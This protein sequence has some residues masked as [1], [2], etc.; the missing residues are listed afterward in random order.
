MTKCVNINHPDFKRLAIQSNLN[1]H[2]LSAKIGVWMEENNTDEFPTLNDLGIPEYSDTPVIN[3]TF[4][5]IDI[6]LSDRA[7]QVFDKGNKNNWDLNKIL[8]ELQIPK[9]QKELLLHL[10]IKDR[11]ELAIQLASSYGFTI[12]INTTKEKQA[13]TR[14]FANYY[15]RF[16]T[17]DYYDLYYINEQGKYLKSNEDGDIKEIS[18]EEYDNKFELAYPGRSKDFSDDANIPTKYYSNLTVP[19]GTN[20]TEN[21]ISTPNII[22]SIKGHATFSTNNGIGWFRSDEQ[23]DFSRETDNEISQTGFYNAEDEIN[24]YFTFLNSRFNIYGY[25]PNTTKADIAYENF[26]KAKRKG[27]GNNVRRILEIQSDLFQKGKEKELLVDN[28]KH[29]KSF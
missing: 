23:L 7:K 6:L 24:D 8:G 29:T 19:G 18:K 4:K 11:E 26:L 12:E 1:P 25:E 27:I 21:E 9:A 17:Y 2:I 3:Y 5:A 15:N 13:I 28:Y 10:R 14:N 16:L 20:Y 22:P